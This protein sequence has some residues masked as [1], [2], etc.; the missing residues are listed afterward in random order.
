MMLKAVTSTVFRLALV[1]GL[2]PLAVQQDRKTSSLVRLGGLWEVRAGV[3]TN[4]LSARASGK[5]RPGDEG[6]AAVLARHN[7]VR[8]LARGN[9][10]HDLESCRIYDG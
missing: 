5:F 1:S 6:P 8:I 10:R 2:S 7:L 3:V 9:A 4:W